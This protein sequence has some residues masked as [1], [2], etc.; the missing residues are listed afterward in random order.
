MC[1]K[2]LR[3]RCCEINWLRGYK[4]EKASGRL[5]EAFLIPVTLNPKPINVQENFTVYA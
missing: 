1:S 5:P 3:K 2:N 4:K